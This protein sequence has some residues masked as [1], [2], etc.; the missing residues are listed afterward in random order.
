MHRIIAG[1]SRTDHANNNGL[2]NQRHNLR[3]VTQSQNL[4]NARRR[5]DSSSGFRGVSWKADRC[6]WRAYI[7][8][9]GRQHHL[10]YFAEVADAARAYNAAALQAWGAFA[11]LNEGMDGA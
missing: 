6:R 7:N 3:P 8:Y 9:D 5:S 11:L 2:D 4:A 10:G 1:Y